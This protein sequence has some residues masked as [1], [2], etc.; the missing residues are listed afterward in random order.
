MYCVNF[1]SALQRLLLKV[2][3]VLEKLFAKLYDCLLCIFKNEYD[4]VAPGS[5]EKMSVVLFQHSRCGKGSFYLLTFWLLLSICIS[6]L[7]FSLANLYI[8][9]MLGVNEDLFISGKKIITLNDIPVI[10]YFPSV[11]VQT[12]LQ[13]KKSF[14]PCF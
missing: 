1:F 4:P 5:Q 10:F 8:L 13:K 2:H 12:H 3:A 11:L 9:K 14:T 6:Q 7:Y